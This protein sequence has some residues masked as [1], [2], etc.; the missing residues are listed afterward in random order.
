M[1]AA[2]VLVAL[3][4][5]LAAGSFVNVVISRAPKGESLVAPG[6]HC[7]SCGRP[8]RW[9]ENVPVVSYAALGGRCRTCGAP[10]GM[11]YLVVELAAGL[12]AAAAAAAWLRL[13]SA[14]TVGRG[15]GT[16]G[17]GQPWAA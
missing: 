5:G 7:R 13:A 16:A 3:L 17:G 4:L 14:V 6:S 2:A 15:L 12:A 10:I 1:A 9:W 11:R 8:L